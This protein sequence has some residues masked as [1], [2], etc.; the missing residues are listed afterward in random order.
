MK[1]L[2]SLLLCLLAAVPLAAQ[3]LDGYA[4]ARTV[5]VDA[6]GW[7]ATRLDAATAAHVGVDLTVLSPDGRTLRVRRLPDEEGRRGARVA[8]LERGTEGGRPGRWVRLDV[9]ADPPRHLRLEFHVAERTEAPDCVLQTSA[10]GRSWRELSR[11]GLFRLGDDAALQRMALDYPSSDARHLRLFWPDSAGTPT[12]ERVSVLTE[13]DAAERLDVSVDCDVASPE[14]RTC[15]LPLAV[16]ARQARRLDLTL[17]GP[18]VEQAKAFGWRL[19]S[20][21]DGAW[22]LVA[23]G[24][25]RAVAKIGEVEGH[26]L[27]IGLDHSDRSGLLADA[28]D[29]VLRLELW[30]GSSG[31]GDGAPPLVTGA[32]LWSAR[33]AIAFRAE[34]AG[35]HVVAWGG[36]T[37]QGASPSGGRAGDE[38]PTAWVAAAGVTASPWPVIDPR[39]SGPGRDFDASGFSKSWPVEF[40][41]GVKPGDVVRLELGP[42]DAGVGT[43]MMR[44]SHRGKL[45]P[46]VEQKVDEPAPGLSG[47]FRPKAVD[48]T[49]SSGTDSSKA[50]ITGF[51]HD[52][53][54]F[55]QLILQ[56]PGPFR[57]SLS[58]SSEIP[59]RR[60]RAPTASFA[61][62]HESWQCLDSGP[63][64][65][66]LDQRTT[67]VQ[68]ADSPLVLSIRDG[69][70]LPLPWVDIE[71]WRPRAALLFVAPE[72]LS[73][74]G[75]GAEPVRVHL[76]DPSVGDPRPGP[77]RFDLDALA[78][79]LRLRPHVPARLGVVETSESSQ[80]PPWL[81]QGLLYGAVGLAVLVLLALLGRMLREPAA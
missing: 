23:A 78:G 9:G 66:V 36:K 61:L 69:D 34:S 48:R 43:G 35:R 55:S 72:G 6:P 49:D 11:G 17:A 30:A 44:L 2:A 71:Q 18:A 80:P 75:L 58:L 15:R 41:V 42:L 50:T 57:R 64:P 70:D 79:L 59:G 63:L 12:L 65:C 3:P 25:R 74:D 54:A 67:I 8:S 1:R 46:F 20:A 22:R 52:G 28:N 33:T 19:W 38:S 10:D 62:H 7:V 37:P 56:A 13:G 27:R 45:L 73:P 39:L 77:P 53:A 24:E 16:P 60:G 68:S 21:K 31:E 32:T 76:A 81:K 4:R 26:T 14:R 5:D 29:P 51:P 40:D 47:R